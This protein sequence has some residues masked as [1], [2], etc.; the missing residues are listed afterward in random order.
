[1]REGWWNRKLMV[2]Q[3]SGDHGVELL[4]AEVDDRSSSPLESIEHLL[5]A[6]SDPR[7][8]KK[9]APFLE[10]NVT[11]DPVSSTGEALRHH[12]RPI[13]RLGACIRFKSPVAN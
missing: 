11:D 8:A 12:I 4:S 9:E 5:P 3:C 6:R 7:V 2:M 13:Y 1:M 10:K